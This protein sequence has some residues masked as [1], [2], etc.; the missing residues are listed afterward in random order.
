MANLCSPESLEKFVN[1]L[2]N[3]K[4]SLIS[5]EGCGAC[6]E[7]KKLLNKNNYIYKVINI[8]KEE[9]EDMF[10]CIYDVTKSHYVPQVFINNRFVGG[11]KELLYLNT[12]GLLKDLYDVDKK[13]NI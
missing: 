4:I 12:T 3:N 5:S 2:R 10:Y 13:Q 6:V 1:I 11:Y 7:A 9:H 8:D